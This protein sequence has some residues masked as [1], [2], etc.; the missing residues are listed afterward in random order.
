MDDDLY[1]GFILSLKSRVNF[2]IRYD[3]ERKIMTPALPFRSS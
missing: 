1:W 2:I 3:E